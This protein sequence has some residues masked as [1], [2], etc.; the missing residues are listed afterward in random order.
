MD[1]LRVEEWEEVGAIGMDEETDRGAESR[2]Q[3]HLRID[4]RELGA[5]YVTVEDKT[6]QDAECL[7]CEKDDP[8]AVREGEDETG[9]KGCC[10]QRHMLTFRL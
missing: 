4:P 1:D 2:H 3:K 8:A 5:R 7:R 6:A 9:D 10:T